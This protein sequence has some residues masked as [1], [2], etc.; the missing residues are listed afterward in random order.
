[1]TLTCEEC[2]RT[3]TSPVRYDNHVRIGCNKKYICSECNV[4]LASKRNLSDH[5]NSYHNVYTG[6]TSA[7]ASVGTSASAS[8]GTSASAS[9]SINGYTTIGDNSI[10]TNSV[11]NSNV[12][13][14]IITNNDITCIPPIHCMPPKFEEMNDY[15]IITRLYPLIY[16]N[17][18]QKNPANPILYV[19]NRTL[20]NPNNPIYNSVYI[21]NLTNSHIHK[22]D[23]V[24]YV[25]D[26]KYEMIYQII[27]T[28]KDNLKLCL[29]KYK[30]TFTPFKISCINKFMNEI[31]LYPDIKSSRYVLN[32]KMHPDDFDTYREEE[33]KEKYPLGENA[34]TFDDLYKDISNV[35]YDMRDKINKPTWKTKLNQQLHRNFN[36]TDIDIGTTTL[37]TQNVGIFNVYSV[38]QTH[39]GEDETDDDEEQEIEF[40]D[41][42]EDDDEG[43]GENHNQRM[44]K[45]STIDPTKLHDFNYIKHIILDNM[46]YAVWYKYYNE[47]ETVCSECN[48]KNMS[49]IFD[50]FGYKYIDPN[51]EAFII[52][53]LRPVCKNC[54]N[55][56]I[57]P[58][59]RYTS[60]VIDD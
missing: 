37:K 58:H 1:M 21:S 26:Q 27:M 4:S 3:F 15:D 40:V 55:I 30:H 60:A 9:A 51:K 45:Y 14:H 5:M 52:D 7:S 44:F 31:G 24:S 12:T 47:V 39:V 48:E 29:R 49:L 28:I 6:S 2:N 42:D 43:E 59:S 53:N 19:I 33:Y 54:C 46:P 50:N 8:A 56:N 32:K 11:I 16:K 20:A 25:I 18:I 34:Y 36:A 17:A 22:S 10:I 41:E 23:G 57:I 35:L 38:Y 13:N